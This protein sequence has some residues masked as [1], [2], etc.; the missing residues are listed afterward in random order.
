MFDGHGVFVLQVD[1]TAEME[2]CKTHVITGFPSI[3]V[4]RRGHDDL[5]IHGHHEHEAY[6]GDRTK[7]ALTGFADSLVPSA[8][9]PHHRHGLLKAAPK[10]PGCNLA[11]E[12]MW[13]LA[14]TTVAAV[15]SSQG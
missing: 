5:Y 15:L 12:N 1:C 14:V 2:L 13:W 10:T 4:F 7:E 6:T 9:S 8:G 11:G 3:R